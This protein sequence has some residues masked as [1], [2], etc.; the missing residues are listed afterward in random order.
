MNVRATFALLLFA[1]ATGAGAPALGQDLGAHE[2]IGGLAGVYVTDQGRQFLLVPHGDRYLLRFT[3]SQENFVLTVDRGSLGTRLLKYDTGATGLA[4]SVWGG[5]TL[6][7]QDA[8][9]GLPVTRED[10]LPAAGPNPL[11]APV[12]APDL[13][14]A[15]HDETLHLSYVQNLSLNFIADPSVVAADGE[16]RAVA[17]DTLTNTVLGIERFVA[18]PDAK[19]ALARRI[20]SVRVTEGA[21]PTVILAGR[22]LMVSFVPGE[23]YDGRA[24]SHAIADALAQLL[25]VPR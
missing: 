12:S 15:M 11:P 18:Q 17:F 9:G 16:T 24:S 4:V 3:G 14:A 10:D 21:K 19:K 25:P 6:Y 2:R 22:A 13:N 20:D 7:T 8:P 1:A 5:V 23:G